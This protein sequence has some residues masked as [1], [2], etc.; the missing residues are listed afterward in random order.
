MAQTTLSE[1][2]A[3]LKTLKK[4]HDEL[5]ALRNENAHR[6]RR[7]YGAT[8]DKDLVRDPRLRRQVARRGGP[9]RV[10]REIRLLEQSMKATNARTPID[11]HDQDDA[12]LGEHATRKPTWRATSIVGSRGLADRF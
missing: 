5:I 10:A 2:L 11:G 8:A 7:F 4:R 12:V 9:T 3:W 6:E 1:G